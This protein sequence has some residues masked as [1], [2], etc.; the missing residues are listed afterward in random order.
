MGKAGIGKAEHFQLAQSLCIL[1]KPICLHGL[2]HINDFADPGQ[3]PGVKF[4][5]SKDFIIAQPMAHRLRNRAHPIRRLQTD[6]AHNRSF[7]RRP[8]DLNLIKTGETGFHRRQGFL[9]RFMNRAADCHRFADR[10]HRRGQRGLRAGKFLKGKTWNFGYH[11]ID[12]R[13][14]ACRGYPGDIIVQLVQRISNGQFG[15]NFCNGKPSCFRGQRRRARHA[16]VHF[17]HHHTPIFGIDRPLHVR[18]PSLYADFAQY[19]DRM[20]AHDLIFFIRQ[21]QRWRDGDRIARMHAH[22]IHI[23]NRTDDNGVIRGV[24]HHFHFIFFPTQKRFI[25]QNLVHW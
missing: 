17:N 10:F 19:G 25:H 14:K 8:F 4:S 15:G 1:R 12:C 11:V 13:L 22:R 18:A 21:C 20:V 2:F 16:R 6:R 7:F 23:F 5:D 9:Q 24:A 3:K